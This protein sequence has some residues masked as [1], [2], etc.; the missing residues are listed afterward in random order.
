MNWKTD[1]AVAESPGKQE[2]G[3]YRGQGPTPSG[4]GGNDT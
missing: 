4:K 2:E 1:G 3:N